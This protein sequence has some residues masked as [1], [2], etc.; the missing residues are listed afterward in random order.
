MA[1]KPTI[2]EICPRCG[3]AQVH[4]DERGRVHYNHA[5]CSASDSPIA[6][7]PR[8]YEPGRVIIRRDDGSDA[9]PKRCTACEKWFLAPLR[10]P[11]TAYAMD[12][13][14]SC[15]TRAG[16]PLHWDLTPNCKRPISGWPQT[17]GTS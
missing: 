5:F 3:E 9:V 12:E 4:V 1:L 15:N 17:G 14:L 13:C 7:P 6:D 16:R 8:T 10:R 2:P 11:N